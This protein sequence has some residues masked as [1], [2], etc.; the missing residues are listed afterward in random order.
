MPDPVVRPF[1]SRDRD[2]V[3]H[4]LRRVFD[5]PR[6]WNAPDNAIA[7]KLKMQDGLF[8]V[9]EFEEQIVGTV[10]AGFD[11]VRGWIYSLAI[12][13]EFRRRGY[14]S[15]LMNFAEGVLR[16]RGCK[17]LNLQ[18]R[19]SND[20]VV[21]FYQ[22]LGFEV[23]NRVSMGKLLSPHSGTSDSI[24]FE[25]AHLAIGDDIFLTE[26]RPTDKPAFLEYLNDSD[27]FFRNLLQMPYPYHESDADSWIEINLE[28]QRSG[29]ALTNFA[30]RDNEDLLIGCCGFKDC[31]AGHRAEIG[32]WLATP[33]WGRGLMTRVVGRMCEYGF[34]KLRLKRISAHVLAGNTA[35]E[36]VLRKNAFQQEGILRSYYRKGEE[37]LDATVYSR[38]KST[39]GN[40]RFSNP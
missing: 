3:V 20:S 5:D 4:I 14:A 23:E 7:R 29:D 26:I 30:I 16:D 39:S 11:G 9:S 6:G 33:Y 18:V 32:Y 27:V 19:S 13:P 12:V 15:Q 37:F 31:V 28:H 21:Q 22:K 25:V 36:R 40:S 17:K 35:S 8:F 24:P 10:M 2:H 38:L 1:E 34:E